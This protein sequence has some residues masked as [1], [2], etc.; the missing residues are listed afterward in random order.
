M[1][2]VCLLF[3]CTIV[4]KIPKRFRWAAILLALLCCFA[5]VSWHATSSAPFAENDWVKL[6]SAPQLESE[7]GPSG[8][9]PTMHLTLSN[10]GP[11]TIWLAL[12]FQAA[13][14]GAG[15]T[16]TRIANLQPAGEMRLLRHSVTNIVSRSPSALLPQGEWVWFCRIQWHE[17]QNVWQRLGSKLREHG[18]ESPWNAEKWA[19]GEVFKSNGS[20]DDYFFLRYGLQAALVSNA[21]PDGAEN[22]S[23]P[24]G[25]GTN[26]TPSGADS[27][28]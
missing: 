10:S 14:K 7:N 28:H 12:S 9:C 24:I 15:G 5:V 22:E 11:R 21:K 2:T 1:K 4:H 26:I 17:Q 3:G 23:P 25:A 19:S 8:E 27:R 16:F 18:F 20:T 6:V 13:V